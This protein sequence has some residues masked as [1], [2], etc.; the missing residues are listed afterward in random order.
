MIGY[1]VDDDIDFDG[2]VTGASANVTLTVEDIT[3]FRDT[4][5]VASITSSLTESF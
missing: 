5:S 4:V 1:R 2:A 3:R